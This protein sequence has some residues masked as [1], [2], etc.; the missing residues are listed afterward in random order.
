MLI[1]PF[2]YT[3]YKEIDPSF[4]IDQSLNSAEVTFSRDVDAE[5]KYTNQR[6]IVNSSNFNPNT[7]IVGDEQYTTRGHL[8]FYNWVNLENR[9]IAS[10]Q[11]GSVNRSNLLNKSPKTLPITEV[12]NIIKTKEKTAYQSSFEVDI[13][14]SEANITPEY[15]EKRL[16]VP[17]KP[18]FDMANAVTPQNFDGWYTVYTFSTPEWRAFTPF[19][20]G[21]IVSVL[22]SSFFLCVE[23]DFSGVSPIGNSKWVPEENITATEWILYLKHKMENPGTSCRASQIEGLLTVSVKDEVLYPLILKSTYVNKDNI[24]MSRAI[25]RI[26]QARYKAVISLHLKKFI[27][28]NVILQDIFSFNTWFDKYI[29]RSV[30]TKTPPNKYNL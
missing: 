24:K 6:L 22:G 21:D 11:I 8:V 29:P 4:K 1:K 3:M 23:D 16:Y 7:G 14:T 25:N 2:E 17:F 15:S 12:L 30:E 9:S 26:S 10:F 20:K 5:G 13:F 27:D 19:F 28:M 18:V